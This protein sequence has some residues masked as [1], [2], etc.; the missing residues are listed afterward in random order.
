VL[1]RSIRRSIAEAALLGAA[2]ALSPLTQKR[3]S[4]VEAMRVMC[5]EEALA[6]GAVTPARPPEPDGAG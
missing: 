2:A 6:L 4:I 1:F 5:D 3:G